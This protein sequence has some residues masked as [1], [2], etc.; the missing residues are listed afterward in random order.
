MKLNCAVL[1]SG[2][3]D[4]TYALYLAMKKYEVKC[5]L[6]LVSKNPESY[7]FHVPNIEFTKMQA[8]AL[9]LPLLVERTKGKKEE[10]LKD[11]RNLIIIAKEKYNIKVIAAGAI[12]SRYQKERIQAIC[13]DLGLELFA[14]LWGI[15]AGDYVNEIIKKRFKVIITAVSADGLDKSFLGKIIDNNIF[16]KLKEINKKTGINIAGEGGEYE[17]FVL[18]GPMFK[19]KLVVDDYE[20]RMEKEDTGVYNIKKIKLVEKT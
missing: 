9:E 10:E 6:T 11:L 20:I 18:D 2:G 14:P 4:S 16:N 1:F 15:D 8:K 17:T 3:K 12:A 7:M 13:A 5:L 19:K